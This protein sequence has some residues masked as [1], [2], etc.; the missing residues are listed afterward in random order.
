MQCELF[1]LLTNQAGFNSKYN[2]FVEPRI[3][4]A[5]IVTPDFI[6]TDKTDKVKAV[7]ELKYVPHFYSKYEKD[8]KVLMSFIIKFHK[9]PD[10]GFKLLTD[11]ITGEWKNETFKFDE[12]LILIHCVIT[13][14]D[15]FMVTNNKEIW[16]PGDNFDNGKFNYL[17]YV[18]AIP[19]TNEADWR[20]INVIGLSEN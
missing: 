11:P 4:D 19:A 5:D 2:I 8:L 1:K 3:P 10:Y 20:Q 17:Q 6:I 9:D 18:G 7:V 13:K 14:A 15:A 16:Q 12:S